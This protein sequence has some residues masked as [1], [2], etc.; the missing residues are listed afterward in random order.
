M[1]P[2][3]HSTRAQ[4]ACAAAAAIAALVT[5][6]WAQTTRSSPVRPP[7][8]TLRYRAE[9]D[10]FL[11]Y[12]SAL[13]PYLTRRPGGNAS[14]HG[15]RLNQFRYVG[16]EGEGGYYEAYEDYIRRRNLDP[17]SYQYRAGLP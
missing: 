13:A 3:F 5:P 7:L 12:E 6:L 14:Y 17:A 9:R 2:R 10:D 16:R 1:M 8:R 11:R 4:A 15:S